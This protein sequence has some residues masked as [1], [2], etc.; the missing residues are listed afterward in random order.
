[1]YLFLR[2]L[3][4]WAPYVKRKAYLDGIIVERAGESV[5]VRTSWKST[6]WS[7][8][9]EHTITFTRERVLG[10]RGSKAPLQQAPKKGMCKFADDV[11][12]EVLEARRIA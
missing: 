6:A 2:A 3:R 5:V 9:G 11:I 4:R 1:M 10:A 12:R 7:T 8:A